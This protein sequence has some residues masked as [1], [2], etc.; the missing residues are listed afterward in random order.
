MSR[1]YFCRWLFGVEN[2]SGLRET[3]A[4]SLGGHETDS[5]PQSAD[6]RFP[7]LLSALQ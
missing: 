5:L 4:R 1:S 7:L 2:L 3:H 6:Q